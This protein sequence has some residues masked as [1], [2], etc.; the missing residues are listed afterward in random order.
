MVEGKSC[1]FIGHHDAGTEIYPLLWAE[2]E[3]HITEY[4]VTDF[5]VGN[6]GAF[7]RMAAQAV[8][9]AKDRYS[10]VRLWLVLPYH[11]AIRP[12]EMPEGY[13]GTYYPWEDER[14]PKRLAIVK[15]N[16]RMVEICGHLIAYV[17]YS[18]GNSGRLLEYARGHE[19]KGRISV[20]NLAMK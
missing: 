6:Y 18:G 8:R 7:D 13:D 4:S 14:I 16:C 17:L 20:T 9:E 15:T 5:F 12:V 2:V 11:P 19:A 3:R 10:G 1:F